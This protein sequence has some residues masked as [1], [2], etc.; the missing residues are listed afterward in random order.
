MVQEFNA[1]KILVLGNCEI[2]NRVI[3]KVLQVYGMSLCEVDFVSYNE[4]CKYDF[5][6]LIGTNK[7]CDVFIGPTPHKALKLAGSSSP[8]QF[9]INHEEYV[10]KVQQLRQKNGNLGISKTNFED[11][12]LRSEK[13]RIETYWENENGWLG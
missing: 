11:A 9:L 3:E 10:P 4:I 12:L 5:N 8:H 1:G 13:F 2:S 7:Y 6:Q